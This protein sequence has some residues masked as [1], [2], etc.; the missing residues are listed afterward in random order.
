MGSRQEFFEAVKFI[1][2]HKIQPVVDT[3]LTGLDQAEKG[4]ELLKQGGQFG[5]VSFIS[6]IFERGNHC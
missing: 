5:K 2:E 1:G 3:V 6:G 4:F